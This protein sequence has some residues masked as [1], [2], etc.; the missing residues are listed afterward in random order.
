MPGPVLVIWVA[1]I[2][3]TK[4]TSSL[5]SKALPKKRRQKQTKNKENF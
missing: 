1:A 4:R 3:N 2:H 5:H